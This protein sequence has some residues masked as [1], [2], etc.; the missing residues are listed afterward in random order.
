[1]AITSLRKEESRSL[2]S[3]MKE[4]TTSQP[5]SSVEE[6]QLAQLSMNGDEEAR[7]KLVT[8]NLRFVVSVALE[9]KGRGV[10]LADLISAGNMGL[11]TAAERFDGTRGFKFISYAVWW[12]R[13]AILQTIAEEPR[14]VRL[15]INR[16][17]EL[18]T[19][20]AASRGIEQELGHT[21]RP[22]EIAEALGCAV[23][24]VTDNLSIAT[25]HSSL[26]AAFNESEDY[27]L[28][29]ILEDTSQPRPDEEAMADALRKEIEIAL[30]KLEEREAEVIRLYFGIGG[31]EELTLE[32]IG[33]RFAC[34]REFIRQIKKKALKKLKHP[35]RGTPLF[36]F[37]LDYLCKDEVTQPPMVPNEGTNHQPPKGPD[38]KPVSGK[39]GTSD[40]PESSKEVLPE[41]EVFVQEIIPLLEAELGR[42]PYLHEIVAQADVA[43][44]KGWLTE[45]EVYEFAVKLSADIK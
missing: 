35:S 25:H 2:T 12:I 18:R 19:I 14:V 28:F 41:K 42:P 44:K 29:D 32:Q 13:Q 27:G 21:P 30:E 9:Y 7:E 45:K 10:P 5:L 8:A 23:K 6:V 17:D 43:V 1:V 3:Y 20:R 31:A 34:T 26:D 4:I 33:M 37:Y 38:P 24:V 16:V 22:D 36:A 15:P 11:I 40:I 39:N